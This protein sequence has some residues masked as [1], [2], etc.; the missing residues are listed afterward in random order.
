MWGGFTE[1]HK[2]NI[3]KSKKGIKPKNFDLWAKAATG[4]SYYHNE[5]TNQEKRFIAEEVPD[6]WSKGRLKI[7]C[8]CGKT[9]D[10]SNL[11]KYHK[12]C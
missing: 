9:V 5:Q 8:N 10:I 1:K 7:Q 3:S 2:Q 4:K 11:K 12:N 6:G